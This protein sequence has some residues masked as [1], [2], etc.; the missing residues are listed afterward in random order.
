MAT[1]NIGGKRVKVDD[2]FLSLSPEQQQ[3]TVDE[4]ASSLNITAAAP[5]EVASGKGDRERSWSEDLTDLGMSAAQ[6]IQTGIQG[7]AGAAGDVAQTTG[8][9]AGWAAGKLGFSP[10]TQQTV[11]GIARK[12]AVPG[13]PNA[14][15][16]AQL[17]GAVEN[18]IGPAYKPQTTAGKYARTVGE[19]APAVAAG[20]GTALR[21]TAT[22][23]VPGVLSEFGGQMAEGSEYEPYARIGGAL[24]GAVLTG[25]RN[26]AGTKE[27]LKNVG[28]SDQAYAKVE[29]ETNQAFQQLR[30]AGV[31]YDA[32]AVDQTIGELSQLRMNPNLAQGASGLR[33][34]IAKFAG[35]GMDFQDLNDLE[36]MAKGIMRHHTTTPTDKMFTGRILDSIKAIREKGAV[37]TNGSLPADQVNPLISK[38]NELARRRIIARDIM[39]MKDKAEWYVS[40]PESGLRNQF[41]NY[42]VKNGNR[43]EDM[44]EAAFKKVVNR[45][46]AL[47]LAHNVGS[48]MGQTVMGAAGLYTGQIVPALAGMVGTAAARK[49]MEIYTR[50]GVESAIRT[51]L[52][53][54]DAQTKAAARN[55][56]ARHEALQRSALLGEPALRQAE[57]FLTDASGQSYS[58]QGSLL[59]Q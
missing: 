51:V 36:I 21:K 44:E 3:A 13:L 6:G 58:A 31:K 42:G 48:R 7:L 40:G 23:L 30:N 15:T 35:K 38:A 24:T 12:I 2:S 28:K 34:E 49:L 33:D 10:E 17:K 29:A 53:G 22:A 45:E 26:T 37:V 57:P 18:I 43:L 54:K 5:Q 9:V 52:A 46:G 4:I 32:N 8:D 56:L 20:P 55:L 27:M 41:R 59:G 1:L 50:K 25:G 39:G 11:S 19:F 14:P 16:S 47:S